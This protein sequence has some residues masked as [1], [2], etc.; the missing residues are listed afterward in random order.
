MAGISHARNTNHLVPSYRPSVDRNKNRG[1][2]D[3]RRRQSKLGILRA[4]A[5]LHNELL[6]LS[7]EKAIH[8]H[9]HTSNY[10]PSKGVIRVHHYTSEL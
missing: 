10:F 7:P 3:L 4:T 6:P 8:Q 1:G 9:R 5:V 2:K